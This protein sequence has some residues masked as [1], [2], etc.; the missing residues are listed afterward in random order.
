MGKKRKLARERREERQVI[1]FSW[2]RAA[3]GSVDR[4]DEVKKVQ[5]VIWCTKIVKT[6]DDWLEREG[7]KVK[8]SQSRGEWNEGEEHLTCAVIGQGGRQME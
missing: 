2:G 1:P 5:S 8:T 3:E 4:S 6:A 7:G